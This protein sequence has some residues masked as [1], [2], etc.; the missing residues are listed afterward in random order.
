LN[1]LALGVP[2]VVARGAVDMMPGL[3][4]FQAEDAEDLAAT[5]RALLADAPRRLAL[6]RAGPP[7]I[8]GAHAPSAAA[9]ALAAVYR[10]VLASRAVTRSGV[11][12]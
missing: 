3:V 10:E 2:T 4:G 12:A 7:H 6:S 1:Q 11:S 9:T 5:I 8:A